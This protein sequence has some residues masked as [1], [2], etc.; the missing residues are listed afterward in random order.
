MGLIQDIQAAAIAQTTDVPTLLRMCKLLAARLGN[1]S[2]AAWVEHE[3]HGYPTVD[4]LPPY[5]VV[6]VDNY[7]TFAGAYMHAD[8]LQ[9]PISIIPEEYRDHYR[10]ARL[11]DSVS[12]YALLLQGD[13][14]GSAK[15]AW[16][17]ELTMKASRLTPHMQCIEAWKEVPL[18]AFTRLMDAI[19]AKVLGF[20]I[21]LE[22]ESPDAGDMPLGAQPVSQEKVTH[23][24]NMN[25]GSVGNLSN[26]GSG[27]SQSANVNP[28][29][30][31]LS[32]LRS[33]LVRVGLTDADLADTLLPALQG[34][35][36]D[37]ARA[38]EIVEDR[39][40]GSLLG[41]LSQKAASAATGV[42]VE[43]ASAAIARA[44]ATYLGLGS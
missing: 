2:F 22:R 33:E 28:A 43:V 27:F 6:A 39:T 30:G 23:I 40:P 5:R 44:I 16:P 7:G 13:L 19:K 4:G 12:S 11:Q 41:R 38:K 10:M 15:V 17:M 9:I 14:T 24:F 31:N 3:L 8:R 18:G 37:P 20:A 42:S 34:L 26:A 35:S 21:D 29:V 36:A 32:A 1:V 25:I